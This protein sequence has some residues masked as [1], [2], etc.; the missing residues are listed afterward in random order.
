MSPKQSFETK[1]ID[2]LGIVAGICNET[3]LKEKLEHKK[4][5][6]QP[7]HQCS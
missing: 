2:H 3:G 5:T 1:R 6:A 7:E 4:S